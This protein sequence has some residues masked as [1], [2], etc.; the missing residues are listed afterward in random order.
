M[1][2]HI[3]KFLLQVFTK[4]KDRK[5]PQWF[6][7]RDKLAFR[8]A[9]CSGTISKMQIETL[10]R[11][12]IT[13][14]V[15]PSDAI[16]NVKAKIQ[17]NEGIPTDQQRLTFAGKQLDDGCTLATTC[18]RSPLLTLMLKLCGGAK[19]RK[20]R[21]LISLPRRASIRERRFKLAVLKYCREWQWQKSV[22]FLRSALLKNMALEFLW[23]ATYKALLWQMLSDLLFQQTRRQVIPYWLI[24]DR[25]TSLINYSTT[26]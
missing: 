5:W 9:M 10:T 8:P 13:P 20:G 24:K 17:E 2:W 26:K 22:T 16:E 4:Q 6:S 1:I 11:K 23:Q 14:K 19:K 3:H 25:D 15:K 7:V 21:S 12:S 18:K